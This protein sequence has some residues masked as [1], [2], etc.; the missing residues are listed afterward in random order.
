MAQYAL[1][2]GYKVRL[3]DGSEIGPLDLEA[4][5]SWFEGGLI[6][7]DTPAQRAGST[8]WTKLALVV[9]LRE[10]GG[11]ASSR[12]LAKKQR[13]R[14]V[15]AESAAERSAPVA[16]WRRIVSS[17]VLLLVCGAATFG[18]FVP[19]RWHPDLDGMPWGALAL[20]TLLPALALVRGPDLLRRLVRGILF[21]TSVG[22]LGL[23]GVL[24]AREAGLSGWLIWLSVWLLLTG[25]V[26]LLA[27]SALG[28]LHTTVALLLVGAGLAGIGRFGWWS[29]TDTE[30][31]V[32]GWLAPP[33]PS[34]ELGEGWVVDHPQGWVALRPGSPLAPAEDARVVLA[35]PRIEAI[36]FAQVDVVDV[37]GGGLESYLDT[38]IEARRSSLPSLKVADRTDADVSGFAA[39]RAFGSWDDGVRSFRETTTV[40]QD[41]WL[42]FAWTAWAPSGGRG[43]RELEAIQSAIRVRESLSGRLDAA[44][45]KLAAALPLLTPAAAR[46]L[47]EQNRTVALLPPAGLHL[48]T[49]ALERGRGQLSPTDEKRLGELTRALLSS[50]PWRDRRRLLEYLEHPPSAATG[51]ET[52]S[53]EQLRAAAGRLATADR[54][55]LQ[56]ITERAIVQR[57]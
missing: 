31:V 15:A 28:W 21:L 56:S 36:V 43:Q 10:W 39:R 57:E 37:D 38:V 44:S 5:R 3:E 17:I 34:T 7:P 25:L 16:P 8:R 49:R 29:T 41:G 1:M 24:F 9:P 14:K 55:R 42:L 26:V 50:V 23:G 27:P 35:Q 4:V 54:M 52:E 45:E 40:W 53:V 12:Q 32:S 47:L 20:A 48:A 33:S 30:R 2:S 22:V 19:A 11:T 18:A 51:G 13:E 46:A 6:G